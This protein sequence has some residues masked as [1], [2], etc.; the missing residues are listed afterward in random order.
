MICGC[1]FT[2]VQKLYDCGLEEEYI[3]E[4]NGRLCDDSDD[5]TALALV[6]NAKAHSSVQ[7]KREGNKICIF[8]NCQQTC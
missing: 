6:Q 5:K 1:T 7:I 4:D 3:D 2:S 8:A